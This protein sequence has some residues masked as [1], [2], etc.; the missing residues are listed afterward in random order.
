[1]K[2]CVV[3]TD[4]KLPE[5]CREASSGLGGA[6]WDVLAAQ[7]A[8]SLPAADL[9]VWDFEPEAE[10]FAGFGLL[11][12][13]RQI[14]LV[15]RTQLDDLCSL[16][17]DRPL[18]VLLKPVHAVTLRSFLEQAA[19]TLQSSQVLASLRQQRDCILD[20]LLDANLQLQ[21]Y[22]QQR[23]NFLARAVH[24]FR[25]PLTALSGYCGLLLG[26]QLGPLNHAQK[27]VL[28][29]MQH[30]I[31]RLTRIATATLELSTGRLAALEPHMHEIDVQSCVEQ[32]LHEILPLAEEKNLTLTVNVESPVK[33]LVADAYQLE[34]VLLNLLDNACKFTPK[35]GA[36]EVRGY[37]WWWD[38]RDGSGRRLADVMDRRTVR[39]AGANAYRFEIRDSG[40]GVP[41]HLLEGLFREYS[42]LGATRDRSGGGLG[43][44][45][46]KM[47]VQA[48]RGDI[49]AYNSPE[50]FTFAF[51]LP[52]ETVSEPA[53][54]PPA[55]QQRIRPIAGA[56]QG[57]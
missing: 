54:P 8:Q 43:L 24:D 55:P 19:R 27:E 38:R 6:D 36:I 25:A 7:P 52:L 51:V 48:H 28:R 26:Q 45:I 20:C 16:L 40:P 12:A 34:Q 32:A 39:A 30:S 10:G 37:P 22:D 56:E 29:R 15:Q 21:E 41:D 2:L 33:P 50:G 1:M 47:I 42:P 57:G 4:R 35:N 31:K 5:L 49:F 44:A 11:P 13:H 53:P 23:T 18:W 17:G 9:Y 3:S 14:F 46:C